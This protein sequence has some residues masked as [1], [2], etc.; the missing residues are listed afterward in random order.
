MLVVSGILYAPQSMIVVISAGCAA[1]ASA[2]FCRLLRQA[3]LQ[4]RTWALPVL[5]VVMVVMTGL[6]IWEF[7]A[8]FFVGI[9]GVIL[10]IA[11]IPYFFWLNFRDVSKMA[12]SEMLGLLYL[13]VTLSYIP[14]IT[15]ADSGRIWLLYGL[16]IV[17]S[18]D[19]GAFI[20]G[21]LFGKHQLAPSIS[22]AKTIE[23]ALGG[24]AIGVLFSVA[25]NNVFPFGLDWML[26][27][28]LGGVLGVLAQAGDL[29]ESK[30]KRIARVKDSGRIIPGQ[31][32]I[33]DRID[34]VVV[35]LPVLYHSLSIG[36]T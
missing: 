19:T 11:A 12:F 36:V 24:L 21:R 35:V 17:F 13:G 34:S 33:L 14:L 15:V 23:G 27:L 18:N 4:A 28:L 3:G 25:L 2:E 26:S 6:N 32:G 8:V 5:S 1:V 7:G 22:P 29:V 30:L 31:G 20:I 10:I 9:L 16:I